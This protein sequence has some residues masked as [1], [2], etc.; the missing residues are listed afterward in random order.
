[1]VPQDPEHV[2]R[3]PSLFTAAQAGGGGS[4]PWRRSCSLRPA[5]LQPIPHFLKFK[6]DTQAAG[7]T[8]AE[9]AKLL[10][11]IIRNG[12]WVMA[13]RQYQVA[14]CGLARLLV[15]KIS[16]TSQAIS[17]CWTPRFRTRLRS[18]APRLA[19]ARP[20]TS[21][22]KLL[23]FDAGGIADLA[24]YCAVLANGNPAENT[25]TDS[26]APAPIG[27]PFWGTTQ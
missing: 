27:A 20:A 19:P 16:S 22:P 24:T 8:T 26:M 6:A 15:R 13:I 4:R 11:Q 23:S 12:G 18:G 21:R 14:A 5:Y 25:S 10:N 3:Y 9:A 17:S 2:R 1:V 7:L